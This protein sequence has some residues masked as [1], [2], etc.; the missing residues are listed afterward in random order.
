MAA[1]LLTWKKDGWPIEE[2]LRMELLF[3]QL[4]YVD[5]CWR[6]KSHKLAKLDDRVWALKQGRGPKGIF[7]VGKIIDLPKKDKAGNGK[8]QWMV[9]IRFEV[10]VNPLKKLLIDENAVRIVLKESQL[11]A[12]ASGYPLQMKQSHM[13]QTLLSSMEQI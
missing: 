10:F 7:G 4:G 3:N 13:F 5:E 8:I 2:I 6:F 11:N 12:R 9:R 1:Y